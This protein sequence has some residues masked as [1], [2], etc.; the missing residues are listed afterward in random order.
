MLKCNA[1]LE[2]SALAYCSI[3][4]QLTK[5]TAPKRKEHNQKIMMM[6]VSSISWNRKDNQG[7]IEYL[8]LK[9]GPMH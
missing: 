5:L 7:S 1:A 3:V 2:T 6:E 4:G 9:Y 8:E